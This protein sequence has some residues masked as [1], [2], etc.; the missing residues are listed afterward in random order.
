TVFG[1]NTPQAI[2]KWMRGDA[3]PS[4]DNIVILAHIL[5]VPIDEIIITN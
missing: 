4:I 5:D 3:M 2:F 1:F